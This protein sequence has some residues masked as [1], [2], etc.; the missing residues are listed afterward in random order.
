ML[1]GA[2]PNVKSVLIQEKH[3]VKTVDITSGDMMQVCHQPLMCLGNIAPET[4]F[5][6]FATCSSRLLMPNKLPTFITS[7]SSMGLLNLSQHQ[8]VVTA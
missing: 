8:L 2:K 5:L 3:K 7:A 1:L 4:R 6:A